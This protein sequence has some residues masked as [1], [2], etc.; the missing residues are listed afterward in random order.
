MSSEFQNASASQAPT[1]TEDGMSFAEMLA[2]QEQDEGR[3]SLEPGQRVQ[4]R[5]VAITADTIFV[6]T[7]SKVDGI[8]D[9]AE[10][11]TD[12]ELPYQVGDTLELY[13]I[14]ASPQEVKLSRAMSGDGSLAALEEARAAGMPVEGR[15]GA[16]VKGGYSVEIMKRRAF[17]PGSQ[18][19]LRPLTDPES[20]LGQ[21]Y[22]FLITKLENH[23]RNIVVS[24]RDLL[25]R[26]RAAALEQILADTHEGDTREGTVSRLSTFGAFVELAPGV[27]GMVHLSELS[28]SRVERPDDAV[29][30]GDAVTVKVLGITRGEKGVRIA[31]SLKAAQEDPWNTLHKSLTPG[32]VVSGRVTRLMPFG[33]FVEVLPG[34]EGLVHLSELSFTKRVMK[35]EEIVSPGDVVSVK[36][37]E[38]DPE[39]RRISLSLREAEGNPWDRVHDLVRVG[40]DMPGT[41]EKRAPFGFFINLAPGITRLLPLAALKN[42]PQGKTL[43][44]LAP[45]DAVSVRVR[46]IDAEQR[47]ISLLPPG[48]EDGAESARDWKQHAPR[49]E[50]SGSFGSLGLALQAARAKKEG[51]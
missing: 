10:M 19:D 30:V 44:R 24:R 6:S 26:E 5:I 9:R 42:S 7:G 18:M 22:A 29:H 43:E 37:K 23:G 40:E 4:A 39:R 13:V 28:W 11:E 38:I 47:R 14:T 41:V 20:V 31:L 15:V 49:P 27:E 21:T 3:F 45:G 34:V 12:G 8:V 35:A 2:Q 32:D 51:R 36:I 33:A 17:C 1:E 16:Q 50:A 46:E 48:E 25:E